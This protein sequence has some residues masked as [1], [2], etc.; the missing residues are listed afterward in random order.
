MSDRFRSILKE[1][2]AGAIWA[3]AAAAVVLSLSVSIGVA[4]MTYCATLFLTYLLAD[5]F[6]SAK[7]IAWLTLMSGAIALGG[8]IEF[9]D[10]L[11]PAPNELPGWV[12]ALLTLPFLILAVFR[13][14][15]AVPLYY[16]ACYA[17]G[18]VQ[19]M[20]LLVRSVRPGAVFAV[21]GGIAV[22]LCLTTWLKGRH[23]TPR[24]FKNAAEGNQS[25]Q[26]IRSKLDVGLLLACG[27]NAMVVAAI[28]LPNGFG[29]LMSLL[30][31]FNLGIAWRFSRRL[32]ASLR[33][34]YG[35]AAASENVSSAAMSQ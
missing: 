28:Q 4:P 24:S 20:L 1:V 7:F 31:A 35:I 26:T 12:V 34:Q 19:N 11:L 22:V 5:R 17:G 8:S 13:M 9:L 2:T 21:W 25:S 27:L 3:G 14:V 33:S 6:L 32:N 10:R 30:A 16:L 23:G 29:V 15:G 18:D